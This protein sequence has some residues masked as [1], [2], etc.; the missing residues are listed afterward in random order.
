MGLAKLKI[1]PL[2]ANLR[3][4][5][6]DAVVE[7]MYNPKEYTIDSSTQFQRSAMPGLQTPVTQFV[8]GQTQT[9]S[10]D[11]FFDTYEAKTDVRIHTAKVTNLLKINRD[12]HAPPV[13]RFEWGVPL[14]LEKGVFFQGVFDKVT[15]KFTMFLDSGIPVRATLSVS[16]SEFR[17]IEEQTKLI[18][19]QSSDRTKIRQLRQGD[20]LWFLAEQEYGDPS[21][22]R[23]IADANDIKNPRLIPPGTEVVLPPLE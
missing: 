21:Q 14:S 18:N 23:L 4:V 8:S 19:F 7:V 11:L 13:C 16:I 20:Q 3:E 9:L 6:K 17:R 12:I 15:Q 22:W 2:K 1:I 5:D 10:L